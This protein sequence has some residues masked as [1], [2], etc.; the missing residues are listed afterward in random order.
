VGWYLPGARSRK[1]SQHCGSRTRR[2]TT[3]TCRTSET[4][5]Q[6]QGWQTLNTSLVVVAIV[7]FYQSI[8]LSYE[9]NI[10]SRWEFAIS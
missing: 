7:C 10:K 3:E 4:E 8:D 5:K 6:I 1:P 9:M 2:A